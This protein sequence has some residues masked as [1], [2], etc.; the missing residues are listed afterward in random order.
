MVLGTLVKLFGFIDFS[1]DWFW[2]LASLGL[3]VEGVISLAKQKQFDSKYKIIK[4]DE[5]Y[6]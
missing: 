1:S 3:V 5:L 6:D 4:K 2:L